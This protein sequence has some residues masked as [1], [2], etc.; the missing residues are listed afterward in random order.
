VR[1]ITRSPGARRGDNR[2]RLADRVEP[3]RADSPV[4]EDLGVLLDQLHVLGRRLPFE[5]EPVALTQRSA[6]LVGAQ[7]ARALGRVERLTTG[8][9]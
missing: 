2:L 4:A 3:L 8:A 6:T 1:E 7:P 9:V 5:P